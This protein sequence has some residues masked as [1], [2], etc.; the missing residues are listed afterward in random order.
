MNYCII[1]GDIEGGSYLFNDGLGFFNSL[2]VFDNKE[3]AEQLIK[4]LKLK[5]CSVVEEEHIKLLKAERKLRGKVL[6]KQ[7]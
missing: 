5:R 6:D 3:E 4:S 2:L 7:G 1:Q